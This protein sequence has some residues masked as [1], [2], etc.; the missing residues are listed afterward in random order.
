MG[1]IEEITVDIDFPEEVI[2]E[3]ITL[4]WYFPATDCAFTWNP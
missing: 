4:R 3:K 1:D 2:P